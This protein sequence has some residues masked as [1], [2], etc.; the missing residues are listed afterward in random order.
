MSGVG[1]RAS[2]IVVVPAK[3]THNVTKLFGPAGKPG[4]AIYAGFFSVI[5]EPNVNPVQ[6]ENTGYVA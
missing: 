5:L 3:D 6:S 1:V 4:G 2:E